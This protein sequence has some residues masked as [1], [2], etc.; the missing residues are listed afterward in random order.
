[1]SCA[2]CAASTGR[3]HSSTICGRAN[4]DSR[5]Q[6]NS[7]WYAEDVKTCRRA[8]QMRATTQ[9][10]VGRTHGKI[11]LTKGCTIREHASMPREREFWLVHFRVHPIDLFCP[12]FRGSPG[13][14]KRNVGCMLMNPMD[15]VRPVGRA[16]GK[17]YG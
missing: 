17:G 12:D 5:G 14:S 8:N 9:P 4:E 16:V 10:Q 2:Y 13:S 3:P 15:K 6:A 11:E 1:M 7:G